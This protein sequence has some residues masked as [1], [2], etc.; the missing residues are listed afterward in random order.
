VAEE[1]ASVEA[2]TTIEEPFVRATFKAANPAWET[3]E[4]PV[5][6][7]GMAAAEAI[8]PLVLRN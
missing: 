1:L 6:M 8:P 3:L 7:L 5:V 4:D 2:S